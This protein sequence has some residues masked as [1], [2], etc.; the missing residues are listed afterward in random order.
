VNIV[1]SVSEK[2]G[3]RVMAS[4][5]G[6]M[7]LGCGKSQAPVLPWP[8]SRKRKEKKM[9]EGKK[10]GLICDTDHKSWNLLAFAYPFLYERT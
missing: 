8:L 1:S 2:I 6:M 9:K 7:R 10:A 4:V 3:S 5:K